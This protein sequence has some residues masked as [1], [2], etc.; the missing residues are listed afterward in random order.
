MLAVTHP[1]VGIALGWDESLWG[2]HFAPAMEGDSAGHRPSPDQSWPPAMPASIENR[3][4]SP[5]P[6]GAA[7]E[8]AGGEAGGDVFVPAEGTMLGSLWQ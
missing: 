5:I 3:A 8:G 7:W 6:R 2:C 4:Y 1:V